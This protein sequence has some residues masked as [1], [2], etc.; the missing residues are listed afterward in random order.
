VGNHQSWQYIME[1]SSEGNL[2]PIHDSAKK[3]T[4][5]NA[6]VAQSEAIISVKNEE[7]EDERVDPAI[8]IFDDVDGDS[9]DEESEIVDVDHV[10][11]VEHNGVNC[12]VCPGSYEEI[13][14]GQLLLTHLKASESP[15][16]RRYL[17]S[18]GLS[19]TYVVCLLSPH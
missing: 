5:R 15:R 14:H 13:S 9:T 7:P 3:S 2:S 6:Y 1:S 10:G 19:R 4:P 8:A 16:S 11:F 17:S 12:W 18:N